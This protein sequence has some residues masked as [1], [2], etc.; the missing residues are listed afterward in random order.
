MMNIILL[1]N[2]KYLNSLTAEQFMDYLFEGMK[3]QIEDVIQ[4]NKEWDK[5]Y[6]VVHGKF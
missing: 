1:R 2:K 6:K 5:R 4:F 3:L